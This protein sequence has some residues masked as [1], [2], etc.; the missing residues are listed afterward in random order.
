M[1]LLSSYLSDI[2]RNVD[3]CG[4]V[5]NKDSHKDKEFLSSITIV[6]DNV[7]DH[8][9]RNVVVHD[10]HDATELEQS[11]LP[12][13]TMVLFTNEDWTLLP[14][15]RPYKVMK[16]PNLQ[17]TC[18]LSLLHDTTATT[19]ELETII[20]YK[21]AEYINEVFTTDQ[22]R[23]LRTVFEIDST[24]ISV[25][26]N[27][28]KRTKLKKKKSIHSSSKALVNDSIPS[29]WNGSESTSTHMKEP[30]RC[31]TSVT[32]VDL[33]PRIPLRTSNQ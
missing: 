31:C 24:T 10:E 19:I 7:K 2:I 25:Q 16:R 22:R 11:V 12:M 6:D 5:D 28:D 15:L 4:G 30:Q 23:L 17:K 1:L 26:N 29:R 27:D 8:R 21:V 9:T 32:Q 18:L 33:P 3:T 13:S 20:K 14:K